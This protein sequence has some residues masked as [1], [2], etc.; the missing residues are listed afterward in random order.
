[1]NEKD[2]PYLVYEGTMARMERTIHR[3]WTLAVLLVIL[4]VGT[5]IAWVAYESQYDDVSI[6]AEQTADGESNNFAIGGDYLGGEAKGN[7]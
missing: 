5:N 2:V 4:L 6:T 3:L 1:M 7:D